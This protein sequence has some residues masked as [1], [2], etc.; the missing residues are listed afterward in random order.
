VER[1]EG[2]MPTGRPRRRRE[3]TIKMDLRGKMEGYRLD[4]S[5]SG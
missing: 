2:K 4:S 1:Q 3:D 5:V